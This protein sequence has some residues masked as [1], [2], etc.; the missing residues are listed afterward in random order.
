MRQT[1]LPFVESR[2]TTM[3]ESSKTNFAELALNG[4]NYVT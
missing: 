3:A 1:L 4:M 2:N